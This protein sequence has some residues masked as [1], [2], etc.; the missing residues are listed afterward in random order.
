MGRYF[1]EMKAI[2]ERHGGAVEKF[3]G[4]AVMAVFGVPQVHEDDALRAVRASAEM[5]EA[6]AELN[7]ELERDHGVTIMTRTGV[8]TG[9]GVAGM[10]GE[11]VATGDAVNVA[12]R[13]EQAAKP[14]EILIGQETLQLVRDA[15]DV[16]TVE[17]LELKGKSEPVAAFRL[18]RVSPGVAGHTRRMDSPMVGRTREAALLRQAFDRAVIDRA[19]QL[20]TVLGPPGVGKSRLVEEFAGEVDSSTVLGGCC[21]PYGEGITFFPVLEMVKEAAG[22][23]DFDAPEVVE[24]KICSVLEGDEDQ[25]LVCQRVAQLMGVSDIASAEETF[26][27]IR[28]MFE[29]I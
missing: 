15:V 5:S 16:E 21:L 19:C 22:L 12:A 8:N 27:A 1:D 26:W 14:G 24:T 4:D 18:V 11:T 28:R 9:E 3:I 7:E 2:L 17:P 6:L 23:A 29:A 20:F 10:D 13:L 25:G